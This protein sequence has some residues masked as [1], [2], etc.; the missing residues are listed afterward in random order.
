MIR[1]DFL[2]FEGFTLNTNSSNPKKSIL[3][4]LQNPTNPNSN[5]PNHSKSTR[6]KHSTEETVKQAT[7][8]FLKTYYK[9]R[10]RA[11]ETVVSYD[12]MTQKGH[13]VDGHLTFPKPDGTPFV[14]TFEAT[15]ADKAYE[16]VFTRQQKQ[17]NWDAFAF[18][19]LLTMACILF[20][21]YSE[22]WSLDSVGWFQTIAMIALSLFVLSAGFMFVFRRLPRYRRIYAIEQFKQYFA[23]EQWISI[24]HDVFQNAQDIELLELKQQ[25]VRNGFGLIR[26]DT[27]ENLEM[28]ITPAR[29]EVFEHRRGVFNF[30]NQVDNPDKLPAKAKNSM[31]AKVGKVLSNPIRFFRKVTERFNDRPYSTQ[32]AVSF[33][34]C[35]VLTGLLYTEAQKKSVINL[36]GDHRYTDSLQ[37]AAR[38]M[39][40]E[41]KEYLMYPEYEKGISNGKST[42]SYHDGEVP[43]PIQTE[44]KATNNG[45]QSKGAEPATE[46]SG[47]AIGLYVYSTA[48]R[49]FNAY[50]CG[51][52]DV[53]GDQ[54]I[55][56]EGV[57]PN[58]ASAKARIE[59]LMKQNMF[60]NCIS[61]GCTNS[62]ERG[63]AVYFDLMF[64]DR[65]TANALAINKMKEF[66]QLKLIHDIK[67]RKL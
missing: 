43:R 53:T 49:V 48:D 36:D 65:G 28:L 58:F 50:P 59:T 29:E 40:G 66:E 41:S 34:S 31:A 22:R 24:S 56:Q 19:S 17:L 26:V 20:I 11:G 45:L 57:Y 32:M 44:P 14:A 2:G 60:A 30:L 64:N 42:Q 12:L 55:V 23:D 52:V 37:Q 1:I 5:R 27:A 25:C 13:I 16:V 6:M 4:I 7:L 39:Q 3:I 47:D 15:S 54:F 62:V 46:L 8:A 21:W 63:Y 51:R 61:L 35:M 18:A 67:I 9:Y 38:T 10:P 33:A